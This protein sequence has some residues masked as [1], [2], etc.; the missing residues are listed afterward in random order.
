MAAWVDSVRLLILTSSQLTKW[1]K[2]PAYHWLVRQ[3]QAG[4]LRQGETAASLFS[5]VDSSTD[6]AVE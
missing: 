6:L 3:T 5:Q 4:S 1:G 2:H